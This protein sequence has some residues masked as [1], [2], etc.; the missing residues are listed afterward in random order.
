MPL[1]VASTGRPFQ[2]S[3]QSL[4]DPQGRVLD[5]LRLSVTDLCN[6]RCR[7]CMPAEGIKLAE[8]H[9]LLSWEELLD[10]LDTLKNWGLFGNGTN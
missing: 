9:E 4:V 3:G 8:Q 7:Y 2:L 10:R 1:S 5:Y 6:L